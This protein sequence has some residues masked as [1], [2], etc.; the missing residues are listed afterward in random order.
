MLLEDNED[1]EGIVVRA[2]E[3]LRSGCRVRL[4]EQREGRWG[5]GSCCSQNMECS[6]AERIAFAVAPVPRVRRGL[7]SRK[8]EGIG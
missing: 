3:L 5:V 7:V 8:S 1:D 2:R 4:P 6:F